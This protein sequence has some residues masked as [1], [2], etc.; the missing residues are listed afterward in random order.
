[1]TLLDYVLHSGGDQVEQWVQQN[2]Y[3]IKTLREFQYI[4]EQGKDQ[5]VNGM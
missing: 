1:L 5:G 2:V 3:I 4:D